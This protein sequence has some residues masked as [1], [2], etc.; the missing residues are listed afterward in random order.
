MSTSGFDQVLGQ[1]E[2]VALLKASVANPV[3]AYL[4]T[5][6]RGSGRRLAALAF[7]RALLCP[8]GG[9]GTCRHCQLSDTSSHPDLVVVRRTG[10]TLSV[11]DLRRAATLAQR[12]PLEA[13]RQVVLIEDLHLATRSA[14]AL[15]KTLEEPPPT[16]VFLLL[17]DD[18]PPE[19]VTIASRCVEVPFSPLRPS[20]VASYLEADGIDP[21]RARTIARSSGGNLDRA[22][23]LVADPSFGAR[24]ELWRS[25]PRRLDGYG[26]T[27]AAL[28]RELIAATDAAV[29]PMK[30]A[31]EAELAR[32]TE[33]AEAMGERTLPGKKDLTDAHA[34]AERRF[35]ADELRAG[36]GVLQRTYAN[37][38]AESLEPGPGGLVRVED[39][40]HCDQAITA[41][42][43][44]ARKMRHNPSE[45]LWLEALL[46]ELSALSLAA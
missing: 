35:R 34:R 46:L 21:E 15:L 22:Q 8:Q 27:A 20:V 7:A 9:C 44:A 23:L 18:V 14:P 6:P 16:T 43:T 45:L 32:L 11:E 26:A 39:L 10:A 36:L 38:L 13:A 25:V 4:F 17:T 30:A 5:G 24:L 29:A 28:A 31:H 19:L 12:R 2:A 33:E 41:I 37:V 40:R 42:T 3:H 1:D